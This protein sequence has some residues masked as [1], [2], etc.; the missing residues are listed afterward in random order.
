M[1]PCLDLADAKE[2]IRIERE[3]YHHSDVAKVLKKIQKIDNQVT[4]KIVT[5]YN[6]GIDYYFLKI[7][8]VLLKRRIFS[9]MRN[10]QFGKREL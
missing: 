7:C 2:I 5:L 6:L 10:G 4:S 8:L 9:K 1:W 3:L